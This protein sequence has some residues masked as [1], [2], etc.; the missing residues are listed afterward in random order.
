MVLFGL[1]G[2]GWSSTWIQRGEDGQIVES[3]PPRQMRYY[4]VWV[5]EAVQFR[6]PPPT[7]VPVPSNAVHEMAFFIGEPR[8][9][10]HYLLMA[11]L[12]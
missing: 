8:I 10:V 1:A 4:L 6:I 5:W 2:I 7:A 9:F 12:V 11:T 3:T